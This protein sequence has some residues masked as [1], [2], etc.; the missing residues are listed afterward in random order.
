[1]NKKLFII[2]LIHTIIWI[3]FLLV[4][5]YI[6]YTGIFDKINVWTYICFGL[7]V[8]EGIVLLIF[9]WRCPLTLIG[10]NHTENPV[11]GFDIFLPKWLAKHNKII[12]TI[13]FI[14]ELILVIYRLLS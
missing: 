7:V 6:L 2:K 8:I 13:L 11:I 3:I 5:L 12:F 9:K 1:M 14:A 4:F 10:K